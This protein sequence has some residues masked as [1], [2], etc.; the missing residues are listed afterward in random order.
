MSDKNTHE[1]QKF[2]FWS[3]SEFLQIVNVHKEV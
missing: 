1:E 3:V 2:T